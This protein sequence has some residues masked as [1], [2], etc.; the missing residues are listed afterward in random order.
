MYLYS[1]PFG[2]ARAAFKRFKEGTNDYL[3]GNNS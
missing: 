3:N 2:E 1:I